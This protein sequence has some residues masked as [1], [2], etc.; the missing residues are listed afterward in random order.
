MSG[1]PPSGLQTLESRSFSLCSRP[2]RYGVR[3]VI[4]LPGTGGVSLLRAGPCDCSSV[5]TSRRRPFLGY[6]PGGK[7]VVVSVGELEFNLSHSHE[8]A[9]YAFSMGRPVGVD[10]E[11]VRR[12]LDCLGLA[13]RFFP[14][15]ER[16]RLEAVRPELL[17][18]AFLACWTRREALLKA[19]G[20]GL[21]GLS[22]LHMPE[23]SFEGPCSRLALTGREWSVASLALPPLYEGALAIEGEGLNIV[24]GA[25]G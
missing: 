22:H 9:V 5:A 15:Q 8:L 20:E 23:N 24:P 1:R 14:P 16:V 2:R 18:R 12:E 21:R 4:D 17:T 25:I 19:T 11:Y 6:Q 3:L 7:P 10:V 13:R